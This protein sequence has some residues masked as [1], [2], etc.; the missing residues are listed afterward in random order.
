MLLILGTLNFIWLFKSYVCKLIAGEKTSES[1]WWQRT[2]WRWS[3]C[4]AGLTVWVQRHHFQV[5]MT[6]IRPKC[7]YAN[8]KIF[9]FNWDFFFS[10]LLLMQIL[11]YTE[12]FKP[13][14]KWISSPVRWEISF[15]RWSVPIGPVVFS[16]LPPT[17]LMPLSQTIMWSLFFVEPSQAGSE[18]V[19]RDQRGRMIDVGIP[20]A[21][22]QL[23][24]TQCLF[25]PPRLFICRSTELRSTRRSSSYVHMIML[26][27][28]HAAVCFTELLISFQ[29][30]YGTAGLLGMWDCEMSGC[31]KY[32][33]CK[34][35]VFFFYMGISENMTFCLLG[36]WLWGRAV[37]CR[38][39]GN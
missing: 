2:D 1:L 32:Q 35:R 4:T 15:E 33:W 14:G 19:L 34:K 20:A 10:L 3:S 29:L 6:F 13:R 26:L 23:V 25:F 18:M 37:T 24:Y 21:A 9:K 8:S 22:A 11:I 16:S 27:N 12:E 17:S 38:K 36:M 7:K 5:L 28:R 30:R 39:K 31:G